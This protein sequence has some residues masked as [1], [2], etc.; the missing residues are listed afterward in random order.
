MTSEIL[1]RAYVQY[2]SED[3]FR[4]LVANTLD[5]V[6]SASLR[7]VHGSPHLA[8][9]LAVRVY[10]ELA[11]KAPA[12]D[13]EV[14]VP[15]WLREHTCKMAVTILREEQR[16]IDRDA[17]KKERNPASI[18]ITVDPAPVGLAIRICHVIFLNTARRKSFRLLSP[19]TWWPTWIRPLH[20]CGAA[21]CALALIIWWSNPFHRRNRIVESEG[22][23]L[24]PSS[25]A[26]LGSPDDG[27]PPPSEWMAN[28]NVENNPRQ[29]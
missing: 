23:Q 16:P 8:E 25:F 17:L 6:Y 27:G 10:L 2:Q 24:T 20:L 14:V 11:R 22:S 29:K 18:P 1:L 9:E 3:A 15:S 28:T 4:E 5:E 12:V 21:V 13:K 26:Q 7:L 19:T